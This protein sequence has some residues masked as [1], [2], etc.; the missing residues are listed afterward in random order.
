MSWE[1]WQDRSENGYT[2]R[3]SEDNGRITVHTAEELDR[4]EAHCRGYRE[5]R[6]QK[7]AEHMRPVAEIP[8]TVYEQGLRESRQQTHMSPDAYLKRFLKRWANDPANKAFRLS[9]GTV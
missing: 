4:L 9:E 2:R 6:Q 1:P 5:Q 3:I 7:F 8:M